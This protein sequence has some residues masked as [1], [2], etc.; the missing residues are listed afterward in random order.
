MSES[1]AEALGLL[2]AEPAV[3]VLAGEAALPAAVSD[4]VRARIEGAEIG[5][6]EQ[7]FAALAR[8]LSF[9]SWFGRNWDALLDCLRDVGGGDQRPA[10]VTLVVEDAGELLSRAPR[11][12][13]MLV[14][15]WVTAAHWWA[16]RGVPFRL[17]LLIP[18]D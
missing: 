12:G 14:E 4:E 1:S 15:T 3:R 5:S 18:R 17:C 2:E 16:Q 11:T 13:A 7:L 8:A 9:P 6:E 10:A